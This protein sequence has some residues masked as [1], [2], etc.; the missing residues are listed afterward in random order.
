MRRAA[1]AALQLEQQVVTEFGVTEAML[2]TLGRHADGT[3][4]D[5]LVWPEQ[6]EVRAADAGALVLSVT[7]PPGAYATQLLRELLDT[8]WLE[9]GVEPDQRGMA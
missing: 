6:L 5:L 8:P 4:R 9:R 7:L 2:E 1:G 3:R